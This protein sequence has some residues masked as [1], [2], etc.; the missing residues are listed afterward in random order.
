MIHQYFL[1]TGKSNRDQKRKISRIRH[2]D[3]LRLEDRIQ[4]AA[5]FI[6]PQS[7]G[8]L[9]QAPVI[10]SINGVLST[11]MDMVRAG[12]RVLANPYCMATSRFIRIDSPLHRHFLAGCR[13]IR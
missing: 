1:P 10:T 3:W 13:R 12:Y 8:D 9:I 11:S 2:L 5:F 6:P 4:M 7:D